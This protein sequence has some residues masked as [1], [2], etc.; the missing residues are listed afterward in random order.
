MIFL[1]FLL[2]ISNMYKVAFAESKIEKHILILH[3]FAPEYPIHMQYNKGIKDKLEQNK[4]YKFIYSYEYLDFARHSKEKGYFDN[5]AQYLK[6]K[7]KNYKP[8]FIVT[9]ANLLPLLEKYDKEIF[10]GVPVIITK[11]NNGLQEIKGHSN[12]FFIEQSTEAEKNIQLILQIKPL[13]KKIYIVIGDSADERIFV[14]RFKDVEK[15]YIDKIQFVFMNTFSY[16]QMIEAVKKAEDDS[17]VLY[18]RWLTDIEGKSFIPEEVINDIC[19]VSKVPVYGTDAQF[20]GS[21]ILGGYVKE[22]QVAGQVA[23]DIIIK[24]LEGKESTVHKEIASVSNVYEFDWRQLKRFGID[25]SKLPQGSEIKYREVSIWEQYWG[26]ICAGFVLIILQT[27]LILGLMINRKKRKS[28]EKELIISNSSLQKLTEKLISIDKMK[29]EFLSNTSHELQTPLNGI[30]NITETLTEG[31]HG[32]IN[33]RQRDELQVILALSKRLSSLV[34]DIIDV[35]RIKRNEIQFNFQTINIKSLCDMVSGVFKH[36]IIGKDIDIIL[37]IPEDIPPVFAD[38]NRLIQV[39]YNLL[40]NSV[41]FTERGII[42]ISAVEENEFIKVSVEDT[43]IGISEDVQG[44]LFN[45]FTQGGEDIQSQYGG[46][47]LGLYVTQKLLELMKGEIFLQWSEFGKGSCFSFILPK[48]NEILED[49]K[50]EV[51]E[52]IEAEI[53]VKEIENKI[54]SDFVALAV[55]DEPTN[56]RI[57]KSLLRSKGYEIL[58][59]SNG[60]EAIE[61]IRSRQDIDIVLMDVMM[62]GISGY[63]ACERVREYYS[64]YDLPILMLTVRDTPEDVATAF[65]AGANDFVVKPFVAKELL[66]R[67]SNLLLLKK[68]VHEA[69]KN[70]M[71]FLQAQI[72]PHFLFNALSTIMSFCF[73]DGE[74]AAELLSYL[75][76]YLHKSFNIDSTSAT[77]T[78]ESELQLTAA[79]A[80][81]EKARFGDRL[82]VKFDI[83]ENVKKHSTLPLTIQPL[84]ENS[85]RHGLMKRE[86][87]GTVKIQVKV[88]EDMIKVFVEDDGMGIENTEGILKE[89]EALKSTETGVG[90]TNIRRRLMNYYGTELCLYSKKDEGTKIWF[91]IPK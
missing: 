47:G 49:I 21:G 11:D 12:Y 29:D 13:T 7:Y 51:L 17:A 9:Q 55:D 30:I 76:Q 54:S 57:L 4:K 16:N 70:E 63:E 58:T 66:A 91:T 26:Y 38:E 61:I 90:L 42:T 53:N 25:E 64:I 89:G 41:K 22:Q 74:K 78:F 71:A 81:I 34:K 3:A 2:A 45:A 69:L 8:D 56:L 44:K 28:A 62:P 37:D 65:E 79:Y 67:I 46:S 83:D 72:K 35:E 15:K 23:A 36:L 40:G 24:I 50:R 19:K 43:G 6:L 75:S 88:E 77:V 27:M 33:Q 20:L 73:T 39:L 82:S 59:A 60:K 10:S 48:S 32:T 5:I 86:S 84:V 14:E 85:I 52:V 31:N 80:E 87:G 18:F 68:S 1:I